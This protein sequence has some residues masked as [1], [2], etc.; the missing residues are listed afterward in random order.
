[1]RFTTRKLVDAVRQQIMESNATRVSTDQIL[2]AINRGFDDAVDM[3]ARLYPDPM[4][5]YYEAYP[6]SDGR[7]ELPEDAFQ[8]RV[9]EVEY[10]P[11]SGN[12]RTRVTE[13]D[14]VS[15]HGIYNDTTGGYPRIYSVIGRDIQFAPVNMQS[16]LCR[17]WYVKAPLPLVLDQ[18]RLQTVDVASNYIVVDSLNT[19]DAETP[20]SASDAYGKYINIADATTGLIK[21]TLQVEAIN[22]EQIVIKTSPTRTTV[23]NLPVSSAIP[24]TVSPDD[25]ISSVD[26]LGILFFNRPL[27][28]Y[29]IQYAVNEV[30]RSLGVSNLS[31]EE[32]KLRELRKTVE[33]SWKR[34]GGS[35][36]KRQHTRVFA[37]K[38]YTSF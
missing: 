14:D 7:I 20:I 36:F 10:Y 32:G 23:F 24:D 12:Y 26:G 25:V 8:D 28:N 35:K 29:L 13:T 5:S 38:P 18:G 22:D 33:S 17:V 31:F 3:L 9:L 6:D 27:A 2:Q 34:R 19:T 1:M 11:S 15:A 21:C 16:V 30:Q 37:N 4:I